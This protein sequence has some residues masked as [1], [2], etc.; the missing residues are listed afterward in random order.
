VLILKDGRIAAHCDLEAERRS[1]RR[2]VELETVGTSPSFTGAVQGLGCECAFYPN[3]Q[4]VERVKLVL[5][6]TI[7]MRELFRLAAQHD[8]QIRRMNYRRDSLED[9]FLAAMKENGGR[10]G[11][12]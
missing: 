4:G 6:E 5:P 2:F 3:G 8:V 1:H 9:I 12:L 10:L 7:E 11:G